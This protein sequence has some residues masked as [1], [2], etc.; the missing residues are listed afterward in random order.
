[1][2][3]KKSTSKPISKIKHLKQKL[4]GKIPVT[5]NTVAE[6]NAINHRL[7]GKDNSNT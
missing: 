3:I 7:A 4:N 1:M 2:A 6:A 5:T